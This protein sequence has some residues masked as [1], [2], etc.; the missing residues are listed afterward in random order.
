MLT[1]LQ[2]YS[3]KLNKQNISVRCSEH[4]QQICVSFSALSNSNSKLAPVQ[5]HGTNSEQ[6]QHSEHMYLSPISTSLRLVLCFLFL[7]D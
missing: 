3:M 6:F 1:P 2:E 5:E 7:I 4:R